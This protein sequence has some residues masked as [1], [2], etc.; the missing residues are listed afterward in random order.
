MKDRIISPIAVKVL[1]CFFLL[2]Q[3]FPPIWVQDITS[4][5]H[6]FIAVFDITSIGFIFYWIIKKKIKVD[7]P[8]CFI[9]IKILLFLI[10]YMFISFLWAVNIVESLATFNRWLVVF[11]SS[12]FLII[13]INNNKKIFRTLVYCTIFIAFVNVLVC[14]IGYYYLDVYIS[15]RNNLMLNGGYGN[16]NIFAVA[17][18]FKLPILYYAV[19]RYKKFWRYT[20]L[21]LIGLISFCLI[22]LSTRSSFIGLFMQLT[23]L[24]AYAIVSYFRNNKKKDY[25]IRLGLIVIVALVGFFAGNKFIEYNYNHY[26]K[27]NVQNFY[28]VGARVKT[29][30][31]GNSKGRLTI[32]KNTVQLIKTKPLLGY[33]IGNHKL[34]IMKVE[35]AKKMDYIVSDHAHNDFLE[36]MSEIGIIGEIL[37]ILLYVTMAIM[38]ISLIM[39]KRLHEHYRLMALCSLLLLV[40]YMND[41]MFNFPLERAVCQL[42]LSLSIALLSVVYI[43]NK[44]TNNTKEKNI[45]P[46]I[47]IF[48]SILMIPSFYVEAIHFKSSIIQHSRANCYNLNNP[49]HIPAEYWVRHTPWLPN[50]DESTKPLA[51]DNAMMFAKDNRYREAIDLILKDNSNPYLSLKEYRLAA[52]YNHLD[53][54]D[55]S[56]YYANKCIAMKPLCYDPVI[57]KINIYSKIGDKHKEVEIINEYLKKEKKEP[58]AWVDMMQLYIT[59]KQY[60]KALKVFEQA[61]KYNPHNSKILAKK[62]EIDQEKAEKVVKNME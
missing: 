41:A 55:S 42:Y 50:L 10:I 59:L 13:F 15:Q 47:V 32:W 31:D 52:Y 18:L 61:I 3:L 58:R 9:P 51:I 54:L 62:A 25:I 36:M 27:K 43:Q 39:N 37:Y 57:V 21:A 22:I 35:T 33:G 5:R 19:I 30:E 45:K 8:F 53:M 16:K 44:K 60:N 7:N 29:I 20:S 34:A 12:I 2:L 4:L 14:L 24:I 1:V 28:T 49:R 48:I 23:I 40:T 46:N 26:A 11:L 17:F 38:A 56:L 6:F